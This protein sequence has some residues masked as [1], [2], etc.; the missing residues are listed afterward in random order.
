MFDWARS[1]ICDHHNHNQCLKFNHK[2]M[3]LKYHHTIIII[4]ITINIVIIVLIIGIVI[5]K[6]GIKKNIYPCSE[7]N[8]SS[9]S[10]QNGAGENPWNWNTRGLGTWQVG[11]CI[12]YWCCYDAN[13]QGWEADKKP[14]SSFAKRWWLWF[15]TWRVR[16]DQRV[17][18]M[19]KTIFVHL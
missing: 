12:L 7:G 3:D 19:I 15:A 6:G 9:S 11:L 4:S 8:S 1:D 16:G 2:T 14:R 13:D 18:M 5:S 10:R 17:R